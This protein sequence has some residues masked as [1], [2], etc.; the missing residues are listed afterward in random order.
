LKPGGRSL[1][2]F[3]TREMSNLAAGVAEGRFDDGG[4]A[5][6]GEDPVDLACSE[7]PHPA[8]VTAPKPTATSKQAI[9]PAARLPGSLILVT[10]PFFWAQR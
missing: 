9:R 10:V 8:T 3:L 7:F 6:A 2:T 5:R 1:L 4:C